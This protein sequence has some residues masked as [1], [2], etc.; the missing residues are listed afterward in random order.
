VYA[1]FVDTHGNKIR[2]QFILDKELLRDARE[3]VGA[4]TDTEAVVRG[5][6]VLASNQRIWKAMEQ[7]FG[8]GEGHE[9]ELE[10]VYHRLNPTRDADDDYVKE[11]EHK[12]RVFTD[13]DNCLAA[14]RA[15]ADTAR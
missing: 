15:A 14:E 8:A 6:R 2:K 1:G 3:A 12:N 4:R 9:D 7:W 11:L 13:E 5:L 10:D